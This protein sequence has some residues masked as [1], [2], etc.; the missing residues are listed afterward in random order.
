MATHRIQIRLRD[1]FAVCGITDL[2]LMAGT[3]PSKF[4]FSRIPDAGQP[5]AVAVHVAGRLVGSA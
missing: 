3:A 2:C 5:A 1:V 4:D